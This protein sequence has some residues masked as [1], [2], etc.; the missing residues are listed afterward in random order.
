MASRFVAWLLERFLLGNLDQDTRVRC[1]ELIVENGRRM[2]SLLKWK[3]DGTPSG[4]VATRQWY[5]IED[6]ELVMQGPHVE[7]LTRAV[8]VIVEIIRNRDSTQ[9]LR[10]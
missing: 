9:L 4:L 10:S 6:L 2:A 5:L 7:I 1:F 3:G 8:R